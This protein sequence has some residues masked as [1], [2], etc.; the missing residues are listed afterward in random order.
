MDIGYWL[1]EAT[2][3]CGP[4]PYCIL[5]SHFYWCSNNGTSLFYTTT[6]E[7]S[8]LLGNPYPSALDADTL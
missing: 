1:L 2:K 6:G 4:K 3:F 8:Y 7:A 5:S